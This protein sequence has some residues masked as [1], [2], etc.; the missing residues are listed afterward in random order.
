MRM[1]S[2]PLEAIREIERDLYEMGINVQPE[3]MQDKNV[4]DNPDFM[5]KEVRGYAYS[6]IDWK[7][8]GQVLDDLVAYTALGIGT[9]TPSTR[10]AYVDQEFWDRISTTPVNPGNSYLE[11]PDVWNE[12]L[13]DGKFSYTYSERIVPQL[14]KILNE[15]CE[16][17][18]TRQAIIN[19]HSNIC[20]VPSYVSEMRMDA[21]LGKVW[22]SADLEN[23]GGGG[24][25][26]CSMYYQFMI[27]EGKVDMIFAIDVALALMMQ[28]YVANTL[29]RPT[30]RFTHFI[31]S[32]HSYAKDMKA[33][34]IF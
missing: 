4:A 11:R 32:L 33:R 19:I 29:E 22:G 13:H 9:D 21:A 25:I 8:N 1:Y 27:R 34:E 6:I 16:R 5:T 15:L 12:F 31:G 20:P 14:H 2:N 3:T 17:P 26:P 10:S 24:R 23:T 28:N 30:G 7:F 18:D